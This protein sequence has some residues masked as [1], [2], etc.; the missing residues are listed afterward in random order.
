MD[1]RIPVPSGGEMPGYLALP[2]RPGAAVVVIQEIF[3]VTSAIKA[4][5][6]WLASRQL[7]A[8][9]PEIFWRT[10]PGVVLAE[11]E[12]EKGFA[13]RAKVNDNQAAADVAA[14]IAWLRKH[15]HVNAGVGVVGYC[16]G[17]LLSYLTATQHKP[18]AAVS[19]YG[20]GIDKRLGDAK[21]LAC[22][23]LFHYAELDK[24]AGP[25]AVAQVAEACKGNTV[26]TYPGVDHA[27][28]RPGGHNFNAKAADLADMRTLSF[29]VD[30][31]VG[32]R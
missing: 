9:C 24:F 13:C 15:P 5:C 18:D 22:P 7:V 21:N 12:R 19:Y 26:H 29:F 3:G 23:M 6:D 28:A 30:R 14:S 20:V 1:V 4:T 25:E 17:G 32:K 8:L 10:D 31:L 27:F 16:W 2:R 11:T